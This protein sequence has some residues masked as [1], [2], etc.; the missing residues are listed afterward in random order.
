MNANLTS[1]EREIAKNL[2]ISAD[3]FAAHKV[4]QHSRESASV[5]EDDATGTVFRAFGIRQDNS[6]K[7]H[8]AHMVR[9]G[10]DAG[11]GSS[12]DEQ[13]GDLIHHIKLASATHERRFGRSST[14]LK[15]AS[16]LASSLRDRLNGAA[17]NES[18]TH[19]EGNDNFNDAGAT[20]AMHARM[21]NAKIR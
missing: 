4:A 9:Q 5:P 16:H 17:P 1:I 13:L 10:G 7:S 6:S 19:G 2:G 18:T 14:S 12:P 20:I 15:A 21:P 8:A 3:K 11:G